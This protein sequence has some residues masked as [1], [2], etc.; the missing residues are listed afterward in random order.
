M[1]D[2]GANKKLQ[3]GEAKRKPPQTAWLPCDVRQSIVARLREH[4]DGIQRV[5][6]ANG[7]S[8]RETLDVLLDH[9]EKERRAA[10]SLGFA[11]GRMASTFPLRP[12]GSVKRAA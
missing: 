4:G 9:T 2:S 10:R 12:V 3:V 5:A 6:K 8:I 1:Q 7:L 11:E